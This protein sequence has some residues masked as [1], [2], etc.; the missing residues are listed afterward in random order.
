MKKLVMLALAAVFVFGL[1][2]CGDGDLEPGLFE[3][4][5]SNSPLKVNNQSSRE[6]VL[7]KC[8]QS[9]NTVGLKL[10]GVNGLAQG[11]PV[12]KISSADAMFVLNV[13]DYAD[14]QENPNSP[15]VATSLL[16]Y[17]DANGPATYAVSSGSIG[18]GELRF[19]NQTDN[20][21][22]IRTDS[23]YNEPFTVLRP[24][25]NK[26][27]FLN[28]GDYDLFPVLKIERRSGNTIVGLSERKLQAFV[29]SYSFYA[30][31][32]QT[33]TIPANV[34]AVEHVSAYIKVQNN[35]TYGLRMRAGNTIILNA[36]NREVINGGASAEY[37]IDASAGSTVRQFGFYRTQGEE[38]ALMD[39]ALTFLQGQVYTI[40][41]PLSGSV[42]TVITNGQ[43]DTLYPNE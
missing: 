11:W 19:Y 6:I 32:I 33:I 23:W 24:L 3:K 1:T 21:V 27:M 2:A 43:Y 28:T 17:V 35:T 7:Y 5:P 29:N 12:P 38:Q 22:E 10:G 14:Y 18:D 31:N 39:S 37:T 9:N 13:V 26:R 8:T 4:G 40:T 30:G 34:T 15:R 25:E 16:V 41:I 36:L 42:A 20:Y